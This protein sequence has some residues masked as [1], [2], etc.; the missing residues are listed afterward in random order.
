MTQSKFRLV[1][2]TAN[3]HSKQ[4]ANRDP[5]NQHIAYCLLQWDA[6]IHSCLAEY[7]GQ[8]R[9]ASNIEKSCCSLMS[10]ATHCDTA[11]YPGPVGLLYCPP[12]IVE[13]VY[14]HSVAVTLEL[15]V[16]CQC[17]HWHC[18]VPKC[19]R[20]RCRLSTSRRTPTHCGPLWLQCKAL[21][22]WHAYWTHEWY[23]IHVLSMLDLDWN[24]FW[25]SFWVLVLF[26]LRCRSSTI[27]LS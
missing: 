13:K 1:T 3:K 21:L 2:L 19:L 20:T 23:M 8:N 15:V 14:M 22:L 4:K 7:G 24:R 5:N 11:Q 17:C 6:A 27:L 10:S 12:R 16:L 18:T 9:P 25:Y 26:I